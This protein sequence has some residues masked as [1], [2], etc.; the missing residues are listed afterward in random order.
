MDHT[1]QV[2]D[3]DYAMVLEELRDEYVRFLIIALTG[4]KGITEELSGVIRDM[5]IKKP[6]VFQI[7]HGGVARNLIRGLEKGG[8]PVYPSPERAVRGL[9]ALLL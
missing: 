9:K 2:H 6:V 3:R 8:M 5:A 7:A 1:A 4:V